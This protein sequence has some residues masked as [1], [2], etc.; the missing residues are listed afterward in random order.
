MPSR[1][2]AERVLTQKARSFL[3]PSFSVTHSAP[4]RGT[5]ETFGRLCRL[6]A[7]RSR[8]PARFDMA[9][10]GLPRVP[11]NRGRPTRGTVQYPLLVLYLLISLPGGAPGLVVRVFVG[12]YKSAYGFSGHGTDERFRRAND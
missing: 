3:R 10:S 5:K 12:Q 8:F 7:S 11:T 6:L 2:R 9:F 4:V 1:G